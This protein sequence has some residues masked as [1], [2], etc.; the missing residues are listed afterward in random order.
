MTPQ[1]RKKRP[2]VVAHP[3]AVR[4][5]PLH[6][7]ARVEALAPAARPKLTYRNGPLLKAV[8]VFTIFWGKDWKAAPQSGMIARVN[9]FF[10]F[11][12]TSSLIDQLSE[13]N[14]A[15]FRI[16]HGRRTGSATLT[17]SS[18]SLSVTDSAL[19]A[20]LKKQRTAGKVPTSTPNTLYFIYLPPGVRVVMGGS[21]SC[22]A[23]CGYHSSMGT[24]M[25]YAVMPYPGCT[26]CVGN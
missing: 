15:A 22:Q 3:D 8:E 26:G 21:S 4:I 17:A 1:H 11:I 9:G 2:P 20:F 10:D 24:G 6:G 16:G 12:L 23:F 19:Q 7:P 14:T 18:P 25:Y 5:V 13:Y